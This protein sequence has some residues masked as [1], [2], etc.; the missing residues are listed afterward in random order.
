MGS[1]LPSKDFTMP[2]PL[3]FHITPQKRKKKKIN[4]SF[5]ILSDQGQHIAHTQLRIPTLEQFP[6]HSA[7]KP[8]IKRMEKKEGKKRR[9]GEYE[10]E[11]NGK[12]EEIDG[13]DKSE[14]GKRMN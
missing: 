11:T 6:G 3:C 1:Q 2:F 10:R 4:C 14:R 9:E 5:T 12:M 8:A 13:G 7:D